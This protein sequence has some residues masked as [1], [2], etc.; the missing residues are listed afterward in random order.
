MLG[1][2][3]TLLKIGPMAGLCK[4]RN[5][6]LDSLKPNLLVIEMFMKGSIALLLDN[7]QNDI[8]GMFKPY[9]S[10]VEVRVLGHVNIRGHWCP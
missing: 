10:G 7:V 5:E 9:L 4:N 8:G 6:P 1:T 2:G 3:Q